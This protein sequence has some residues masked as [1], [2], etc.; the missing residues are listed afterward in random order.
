M[1]HQ[2][3]VGHVNRLRAAYVIHRPLDNVLAVVGDVQHAAVGQH[4]FHA[5]NRRGL[6]VGTLYAELS[7][8]LLDRGVICVGQAGERG[9]QQGKHH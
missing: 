7:E 4:G 6:N 9:G 1:G 2:Q 3:R 5:R 8:R